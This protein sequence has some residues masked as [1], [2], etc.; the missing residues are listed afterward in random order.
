MTHTVTFETTLFSSDGRNTG[1]EVPAGLLE[2]WG[3]GKRV[4]V[5][6]D[7]N[8]FVYP[9]TTA[10]MRGKLLLPFSADKRRA[11]GIAAG[12]AITVTLTL[13]TS[14]RGVDLPDDLVAALDAA[15]LRAAF[16][17]LAPSRRKEHIRSVVEAKQA[18]TRERRIAA[19][20]LSM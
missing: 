17:A 8:G 2:G 14:E 4:P 11:T 5:L 20:V 7:V 18:A 16:D 13:D 15:G 10:T 3:R 12:D 1:I 6:V 19:V 9:S